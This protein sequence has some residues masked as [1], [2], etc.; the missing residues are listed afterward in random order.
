MPVEPED[1]TVEEPVLLVETAEVCLDLGGL[2][3]HDHRR[4]GDRVERVDL[5][6]EVDV[7]DRVDGDDTG[8]EIGQRLPLGGVVLPPREQSGD[9]R[10]QEHR[11]DRADD[12]AAPQAGDAEQAL[13]PTGGRARLAGSAAE[14]VSR[15]TRVLG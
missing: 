1:P 12:Q 8:V 2:L 5:L 6:R 11:E 9:E 4:L 15:T 7:E 3:P 13:G 14:Q 10:E